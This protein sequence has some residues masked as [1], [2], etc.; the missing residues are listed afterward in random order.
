[1]LKNLRQLR[2]RE[3]L[4]QKRLAEII[5]VSQQSINKYENHEVEPTL[6]TLCLLADHFGTTLDFL[7]DRTNLESK[8]EKIS[9]PDL[10][11]EEI[12]LIKNY[13]MSSPKNKKA[14][15]VLINCLLEE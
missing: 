11:S 8:A 1:M 14:V 6:E 10:S 4:S 12:N 2:I 5:N 7:A 15:Q 9:S 13:R 3:G